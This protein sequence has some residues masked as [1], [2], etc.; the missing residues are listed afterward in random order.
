MGDPRPVPPLPPPPRARVWGLA[1]CSVLA[2]VALGVWTRGVL[3]EAIRGRAA[4]F[5]QALLAAN[6]TALREWNQAQRERAEAIAALPPVVDEVRA[7]VELAAR[8]PGGLAAAPA[9]S[10]LAALLGRALGGDDFLVLDPGLR[11]VAARHAGLVGDVVED[12]AA[13]AL[14]TRVAQG[15]FVTP[16]LRSAIPLPLP[17]GTL[18]AGVPTLFACAPVRTADGGPLAVLAVR[19]RPEAELTRILNRARA[20]ASGETYAFDRQGV[21]LSDSRFPEDLRRAGLLDPDP[22]ASPVLTL[23]LRDPGGDLRRQAAA[24][25]RGE[26]P[27]M[28]LVAEAVR[29]TSGADMDGHRDYRGAL[30]VGAWTWLEPEGFGVAIQLDHEEAFAPLRLLRGVFALLLGL[31]ALAAAGAGLFF[32]VL[33]RARAASEAYHLAAREAVLADLRVAREIQLEAVPRDLRHLAARGVDAAGLLEP[34]LEVGGDLFDLFPAGPDR[35]CLVV[36]D[37]S[38]KGIPAALFMTMVLALVRVHARQTADPGQVLQRVNDELARDNARG[39]FVTLLL[40]FLDP[41]TGELT[42]ASGGHLPPVLLPAA[43][44]PALLP[45]PAG[46]IVGIDEGLRFPSGRRSLEPGDGLVVYTDGVTEA[47]S[48]AGACWGEERLLGHLA[49]AKRDDAG[50]LLRGVRRA[51]QAWAAGAPQ[52]DDIALLALRWTPAP[53]S[54]SWELP[55]DPAE[56]MRVCEALRAVCARER[57]PEPAVQDLALAVEEALSNVVRHAYR[58]DPAGRIRVALAIDEGQVRVAIRDRGPAFDP[59]AAPVPDLTRPVDERPPGGLGVHLLRRVTDAQGYR[60][61]GEE[62]VLELVKRRGA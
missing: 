6:V 12:P 41:A 52:S 54:R 55:A 4:A 9:Q 22:R 30:V 25:P 32:E 56:V 21:L 60:R 48:P 58:G 61:E 29:G 18:R 50:E 62:N 31:V 35:L 34:A 5:Q 42:W 59:L 17:D 14:V 49:A 46:T 19:L 39:M 16:P 33:F 53:G 10:R 11:V 38:G 51:V 27:L 2:V 28:H 40:G 47:M 20:G 26:R 57:V 23:E 44:A 45:G 3:E 1:L 13:R 43:G 7:L 8:D 36:G 37:V 15:G 24:G